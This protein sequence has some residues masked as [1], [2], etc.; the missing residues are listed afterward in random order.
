MDPHSPVRDEYDF[1]FCGDG[2]RLSRPG[3]QSQN[4]VDCPAVHRRPD[5]Y[6]QHVAEGLCIASFFLAARAGRRAFMGLCFRFHPGAL[7][8]V[9]TKHPERP[10]ATMNDA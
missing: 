6:R 10:C 2:Y 7:R 1:H 5:R 8:D 4:M 9:G 3:L